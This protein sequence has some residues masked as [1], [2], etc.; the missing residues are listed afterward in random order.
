LA[1]GIAFLV[2]LPHIVWQVV[3]GWPTLQFMAGAADK[4]VKISFP[5]FLGGQVLEMH[6]LLFPVWLTG[7]GW[8]LFSRQGRTFRVLGIIY[9]SVFALLVISGSARSSYLAPA[10]P[11]L[12]ASGALLIEQISAASVWKFLRVSAIVMILTVGI[13]IAPLAMPVLPVKMYAEYS[14]LLSLTP[15]TDEKHEIDFLPQFFADMHGWEEIVAAVAEVYEAAGPEDPERWAVFTWNYGVA[16]AVDFLGLRYDLPRAI[17]GHNNYWLWGPG[18]PPPKNLIIVGGRQEDYGV[19]GNLIEAGTTQC[20]YCMPYEN[21]NPIYVCRNLQ[22]DPAD[23][24]PEIKQ[25]R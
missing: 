20:T 1:A 10:Y 6:P 12:F 5:G 21:N 2:F 9:I 22:V 13:A 16:G 15:K 24:W 25:F 4:M 7:L 18:D 8:Y 19:C 3:Y 23:I 17:S 11:M 14:S